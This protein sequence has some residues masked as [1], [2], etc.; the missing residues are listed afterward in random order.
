MIQ[1]LLCSLLC[2]TVAT[3]NVAAFST[4]LSTPISRTIL[5]SSALRSSTESAAA[6]DEVVDDYDVTCYV[7]NDEEIITE[8]E[9]PHVVCTSEPEDVSHVIMYFCILVSYHMSFVIC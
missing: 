9:K 4:I 8:G 7:V 3:V 2:L 6:T 5:P 1:R